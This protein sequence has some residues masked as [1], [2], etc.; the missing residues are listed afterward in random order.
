MEVLPLIIPKME[1][2][3]FL[4]WQEICLLIILNGEVYAVDVADDIVYSGQVLQARISSKKFKTDG[5][6]TRKNNS[7]F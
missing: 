5:Q 3:M 1:P 6:R 2:E 4:P 7:R